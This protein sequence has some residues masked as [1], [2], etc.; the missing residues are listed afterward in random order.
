[1]TRTFN[2]FSNVEWFWNLKNVF[3]SS[4]VEWFWNLKN[5]F[6]FS[7]VK[8]SSKKWLLGAAAVTIALA[9][10]SVDRRSNFDTSCR[11]WRATVGNGTPVAQTAASQRRHRCRGLHAHLHGQTHRRRRGRGRGS[12]GRRGTLAVVAVVADHVVRPEEAHAVVSA[13]LGPPV[14]EPNLN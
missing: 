2:T 11:T 8:C 6:P 4:N 5:V 9:F 14:W 1:M 12:S 7:N 3:P 13:P 10:W